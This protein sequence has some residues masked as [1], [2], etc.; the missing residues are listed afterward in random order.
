MRR[1]WLALVFFTASVAQA[2][3]NPSGPEGNAGITYLEVVFT[4]PAGSNFTTTGTYQTVDGTATIADNDYLP[5]SG[6]FVIPGGS[7]SSEPIQVGIVG[8]TKFEAN[9]TFQLLISNVQGGSLA[10]PGPYTFTIVNDDAQPTITVSNA[11]ATEGNS[12]TTPMNFTVTLSAA[13]GASIVATYTTA[14]GTATSGVDFGP[15]Q[16][17]LTFAPGETAKPVTVNVIGDTLFEDNET[18]TLNVTSANTTV[19]GTGTIVND[20]ERPA[21]TIAIVSGNN[22]SARL[23]QKLAQPLVVRVTNSIGDPVRGISVQWS[24]TTGSATLDATSSTTDAKGEASTN[25]TVNSVGPIIVRASAAG[26]VAPVNFTINSATSFES[27]AQGPVAIPVARALDAI[28]ARNEQTF[29]SVCRFLSLTPDADF[30]ATLE[31][32]APQQ[33]GAQAKMEGLAVSEVTRGIAGRLAARRNGVERFSTNQLQ[34][35]VNGRALPIAALAAAFAPQEATDAGGSDESDYNGWSAF[36]SGSLGTGERKPGNGQLRYDLDSQGLMLGADRLFGQTIGG[37]SLNLSHLEA[38]LTEGI[39][40]IDA[41]GWALSVYASRGGLFS[42]NAGKFDGMHVDGSLT[43]GNNS[44]DGKRDLSEV[45]AR[46]TSE[47]DARVFA[48]SAGTGFDAHTGRTD[49]D[50]SLGG[51]WS[52][53]DIDELSEEGVGPLLLFVEGHEVKSLTGTLGLNAR[54]AFATPFGSLLPSLRAELV[55][56]FEDSA[57]LVT[58]RFLRDRL[59][60]SF[61]VPVDQPDANYGRIGAGLQ[62]VFPF[63]WS[64]SIEANQDVMR[65]DLKFRNVQFTVYKSF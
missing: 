43:F 1:W 47:N 5:A 37:A 12:G 28:C 63:G 40:T 29:D 61:T 24:V 30:S 51:T 35:A 38:D 14:A 34:V 65:N 22:Q 2:A 17:S 18:F 39:G 36:I 45:I 64:A 42:R 57:R 56:E 23:G 59:N 60:T 52:R 26:I 11:S 10:E 20:D 16:G 33:S 7:T 49:F 13:A 53:S 48:L 44:Y 3:F 62:A 25:L 41:N 32:L 50:L 27:R 58:A 55:H 15:A 6:V 8:D 19:S 31:R 46:A 21:A 4:Q 54:T 9:E